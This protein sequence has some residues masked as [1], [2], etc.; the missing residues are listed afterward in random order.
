MQPH[1]I[2]VAFD[3][4]TMYIDLS[5][6]RAIQ[7]PLRLFPILDEA[8]SE[9]R[10]HLA[11]SLDGQQLFWPELD[12]DMNVTALLNAVARKTMH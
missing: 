9:Q 11:I 12:E 4:P 1:A 5:D 3:G 6:G 8:S 10:E 2:D 7:L